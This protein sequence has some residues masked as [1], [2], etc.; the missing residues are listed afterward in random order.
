MNLF[1][2]GKQKGGRDGRDIY[3]NTIKGIE[4]ND[5]LLNIYENIT[6]Q[7]EV[8]L[9]RINGILDFACENM[10]YSL[11]VREHEDARIVVSL[12]DNSM[13]AFISFLSPQGSGNTV[14]PERIRSALEEKGIV[15][16]DSGR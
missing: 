14:T 16:R 6:I 10:V 8:A 15:Q 2:L 11:R 9:S 12:S 7:D 5:P 13:T 3:G 4:G 1:Q